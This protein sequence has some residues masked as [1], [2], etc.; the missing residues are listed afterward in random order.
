GDRIGGIV[1]PAFA[2]DAVGLRQHIFGEPLSLGIEAEVAAGVHLAAPDLAVPVGL[3][4]VHRGIRR[5]YR[6]FVN[7][8]LGHV[9]LDQLAAATAGPVI[10]VQIELAARRAGI[11]AGV[12]LPDLAALGVG[13]DHAVARPGAAAEKAAVGA[14]RAAIGAG[15][16]LGDDAVHLGAGQRV[17]LADFAVARL[18]DVAVG[19]ER[20]IA[21]HRR[22]ERFLDLPGNPLERA[23]A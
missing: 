8:F 5:R 22:V 6:E 11:E 14:D 17:D 13:N 16:F 23:G 21:A 20:I 15:E 19:I 1:D 10:V 12:G 7:A 9:E 3:R 18:P 2:V 4:G